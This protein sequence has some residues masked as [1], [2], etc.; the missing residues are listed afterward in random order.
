MRV[1][2]VLLAFAV[3]PFVAGVSQSVNG[4]NCDNGQGD[5][6]RSADGTEHAHHGRCVDPPSTTGCAVTAPLSAG[7]VSITGR[8]YDATA[9]TGLTGWCVV[10]SGTA[11]ATAQS[12][13][14]GNYTFTGLSGGTYTVCETVTSGWH[15]TFPGSWSGAACGAGWGWTFTLAAGDAASFVDFGNMIGP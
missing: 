2:M 8:V 12:D 10:L 11:T 6:H 7:T 3:T 14:L 1:L 4:S 9:G 5:L 13:A 15:E